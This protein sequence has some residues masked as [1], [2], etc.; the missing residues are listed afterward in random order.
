MSGCPTPVRRSPHASRM[1][2]AAIR[3]WWRSWSTHAEAPR[4]RGAPGPRGAEP[5][6]A[7]APGRR[8]SAR[9]RRSPRRSRCW[10]KRRCGWRRRWPG[11]T[12]PSPTAPPM[13]SSRAA[14][15]RRASRCASSQ[16]LVGDALVATI[17]PFEL[18]ARHR[19][20]AALLAGDHA[21]SDRIAGH[22]LRTRPGDERWVCDALR[23]AAR[24]AMGRGDPAVAAELLARA[25]AEPPA[26][27]ERGAVLLELASAQA[28][29][30]RPDAIESFERALASED[31]RV[32]RADAWRGLSRLLYARGEFS[33]RRERRGAR[34]RRAARRRP[35]GRA[36]PGGRADRRLQ[37]AGARGRRDRAAR[38]AGRRRAADRADAAGDT[39]DS[40][41]R[42]G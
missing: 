29:A 12:G 9:H 10:V 38:R 42:R 23:Q 31:D 33:G 19:R 15:S 24:T 36:H 22:L 16:P 37:R 1:P 34:P 41:R 14:C 35:A 7:P 26:A 20:A 17:A 4:H 27:D 8:R 21:D 25:L 3:C 18:A 6:R 32:R 11:S 28:A 2:R 39:R 40:T 13:S 30:G 5:D